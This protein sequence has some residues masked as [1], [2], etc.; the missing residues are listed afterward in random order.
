MRVVPKLIPAVIK[1]VFKKPVTEQYPFE[2]PK[3]SHNIRGKIV[4]DVDKCVGCG[5]CAIYCPSGAIEMITIQEVKRRIPIFYLD[6]CIFCHQCIEACRFG[7]IK[8]S[9]EFELATYNKDTLKI[10]TPKEKVK[11]LKRG[12]RR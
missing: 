11:P 6:R 4:Y 12:V 7:A 2:P 5:L 10:V 9:G 8:P 1:S 3:P